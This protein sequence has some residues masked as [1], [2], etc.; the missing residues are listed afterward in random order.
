MTPR[1]R[2]FLT[3]LAELLDRYQADLGYTN[4]DD[5]IHVTFRNTGRDHKIGY[6][7]A[8]EIRG[9]MKDGE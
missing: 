8:K 5:G 6:G 3:Q 2:S 7:T 1:E 9:I 4:K